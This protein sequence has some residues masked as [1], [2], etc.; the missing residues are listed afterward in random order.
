MLNRLRN[1]KITRWINLLLLINFLNLSASFYQVSD[2]NSFF[3][4]AEDPLDSITELVLEYF[5]EMDDDTV[6]GT[7][8]PGEKRS[9]LD[10]KVYLPNSFWKLD[11]GLVGFWFK[12]NAYYA[13]FFESLSQ[14][15][16]SP[17]PKVTGL[18]FVI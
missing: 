2:T 18:F 10:L 9:L 17:P 16:V 13:D 15:T 11:F 1:H 3:T 6:P 14:E 7:E 8:V 12:P 5:L 4:K